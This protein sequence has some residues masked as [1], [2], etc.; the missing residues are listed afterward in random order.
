MNRA[1]TSTLLRWML[2]F[3]LLGACAV[4]RDHEPVG[5]TRAKA[6]ELFDGASLAGWR[7]EARFWS[8]RDGALVGES[9]A[10]NPCRETTYLVWDGGTVADF[11]LEFDYRI[12]GGNSGVQFRSVE[13]RPLALAGYQADIEDGPSWTGCLYEQDGRGVCATRG[14]RVRFV[15]GGRAATRFADAAALQARVRAR[16]WNHYSV[17]AR[18]KRIELSINGERTVD[19]LDDD[20][21]A[22]RASGVLALQL[23]AGAPMRVEFKNLRLV[24]LAPPSDSEARELDSF[25]R[26]AAESAALRFDGPPPQWIWLDAQAVD[27]E[28]ATLRRE[29]DLK[30][31]PIEA[32]LRGA[33]DNEL[34]AF[35]GGELAF[36]HD[37]WAT[38]G[39]RDVTALLHEGLNALTLCARNDSGPAAAW[40]EL[41]VDGADGQRLRIVSDASF[42]AERP[43]AGREFEAWIPADFESSRAAG[44]QVLGEFGCAPWGSGAA[45][46]DAAPA[47]DEPVLAANELTLPPGF[48]AELLYSVP[49]SRQ[50][51][52]VTLCSDERGRLYTSDQNGHLYRITLAANSADSK[53]VDVEEVPIALGR[54]H[55]LCW[56][57]G[58]L[59][60]VV[61]EGDAPAP[62]LYRARDTDGDDRLDHVEL[63]RA[64]DGGGEHGPHAVLLG[65][66]GRNEGLWIIAGNFTKLPEPLSSSRVPRTWQEDE[67]LPHLADPNNHD[68]H[69]KAPGGWVCRT[70]KDGKEW[71]LFASG[72]RNSYD[73]AFGPDDELFTFDSDMEWDIGAPWYRATRILHLVSGADFGWR[74]GSAKWNADWP[75]T[76]PSVCDL[77]IGSPTG[78]TFGTGAKFPPKYEHALFACDWAYGTIHAVFLDARGASFGA[79]H[80]VF[81]Q[82]KPFPVTDALVGIDGALYVTIGGRGT[83]SALYRITWSGAVDAA[84]DAQEIAR[85][86]EIGTASAARSRRREHAELH[87]ATADVERD[88]AHGA[89]LDPR[90]LERAAQD[91]DSPDPFLRQAA[92]IACERLN[93]AAFEALKTADASPARLVARLHRAGPDA[94]EELLRRLADVDFA[95]CTP[96]QAVAYARVL[97]LTLLRAGP[98]D[99]PTRA[100]LA[101]R[102]RPCLTTTN[103][104]VRSEWAR[105]LGGLDDPLSIDPILEALRSAST[106]EERIHFAHCLLALHTGWTSEQRARYFAA[107]DELR[108]T[109]KG[110]ASL[111]K[112]VERIR[113]DALELVPEAERAAYKLPEVLAAEATEIATKLVHAWTASEI[114]ALLRDDTATTANGRKVFEKARCATCHRFGGVGGDTGPDLSGA[115][116]RFTRRDLVE[117]LLEPSKV[118]S[119]QF[120]DVELITRDGDLYVGRIEKE[121]PSA[122]TLRRMPPKED[123]IELARD[124]IEER[125]F[126][127]F[128]RMPAGLLDVLTADEVRALFDYVLASTP[129]AR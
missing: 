116:A 4:Q 62:G 46:A 51:S 25:P 113:S 112:F 125:R 42:A 91:L 56:A 79:S 15:P 83:Q 74:N 119:D 101:T 109:A 71:E 44:A 18:G 43:A 66:P 123:S 58:A 103:G 100:A 17:R 32:R 11:E 88:A 75:D 35:V 34:R 65:P 27:H 20:P 97:Q 72:L 98:L 110:G 33:A 29:F 53:R 57:Y 86:R 95:S 38:H 48:H 77:G 99:A 36:A 127:P 128:S 69:I 59:Y 2:P 87:L 94:R 8:V 16:D 31:A 115:G 96:E 41:V 24:E 108:K 129:A 63:L 10:A 6:R 122:L 89:S 85:G 76:L 78:V 30:F 22:A 52:W 13:A 5:A 121:T 84:A 93:A 73:L 68:P 70:D 28:I 118:I 47:V 64:F 14:E 3:S 117:A 82:G 54:A 37:D 67:L 126:H 124:E 50:G 60:V 49:K 90:E 114:E 80:E 111:V 45:S 26:P 92:R 61:S 55:G 120:R 19:V 1:T 7:G 102:I 9:T 12:H 105:V 39:E 23:H 21:N 106:Q 40:V 104:E 107:L 81:A